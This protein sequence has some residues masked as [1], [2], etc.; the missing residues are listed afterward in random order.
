M[1]LTRQLSKTFVVHKLYSLL[2][3]LL[4]ALHVLRVRHAAGEK[5]NKMKL[6]ANR[7]LSF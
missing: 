1:L 7:Q 2:F 5:I 3:V 6:P 4:L